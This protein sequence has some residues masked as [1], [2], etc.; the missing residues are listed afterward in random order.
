MVPDLAKQQ[1]ALGLCGVEQPLEQDQDLARLHVDFG[2]D[3]ELIKAMSRKSRVD[4]GRSDG[5]AAPAQRILQ[6]VEL[7]LRFEAGI[8]PDHVDAPQRRLHRLLAIGLKQFM[9]HMR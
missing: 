4:L 1:Y 7:G 9:P 8:D 6:R 2:G 3:G 5:I